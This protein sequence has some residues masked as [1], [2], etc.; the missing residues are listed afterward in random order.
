V[1][2]AKEGKVKV[3]VMHKLSEQGIERIVSLL[4]ENKPSPENSTEAAIGEYVSCP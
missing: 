4:K 3:T 1:N 2:E